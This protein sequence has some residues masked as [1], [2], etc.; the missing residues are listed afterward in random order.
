MSTD[1]KNHER[2]VVC[3]LCKGCLRKSTEEYLLRI[4]HTEMEELYEDMKYLLNS[5]CEDDECYREKCID[6]R[7]SSHGRHDKTT[8][9]Y[10]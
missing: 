3:K 9:S 8:R 1:N 5:V 7:N 6:Y 2:V 10:K 4:G